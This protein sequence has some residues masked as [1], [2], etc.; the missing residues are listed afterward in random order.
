MFD[1]KQ[2]V[3]GGAVVAIIEV[4]TVAVMVAAQ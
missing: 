3:V 4:L 1:L 2:L